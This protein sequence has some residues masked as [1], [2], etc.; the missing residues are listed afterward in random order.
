M[1]IKSYLLLS[2]AI[3]I[4]LTTTKPA[5]ATE[6][7]PTKEVLKKEL[8]YADLG[9]GTVPNGD[10]YLVGPYVK[11]GK[12]YMSG[13]K[14]ADVS[15]EFTIT[16]GHGSMSYSALK[17]LFVQESDPR[18]D[19]IMFYGIGGS[20]GGFESKESSFHGVLANAEIGFEVAHAASLKTK[21]QAGIGYPGYPIP[22]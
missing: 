15:S 13:S 8:N 1:N 20:L 5:S 9:I 4:G 6:T 10:H 14:G 2:T 12:R 3:A 17:A 16:E 11:V 22:T 21:M 7:A 18:E 19:V